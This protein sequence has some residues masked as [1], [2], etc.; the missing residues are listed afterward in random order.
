MGADLLP[1]SDWIG[2]KALE[3]DPKGCKDEW[4]AF[5]FTQWEKEVGK[6]QGTTQ[7][8]VVGNEKGASGC[9]WTVVGPVK[10]LQWELH[11]SRR[12]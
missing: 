4:S 9:L 1:N 2:I 7:F 12:V 6:E 10:A 3:L 5:H 11:A 8:G